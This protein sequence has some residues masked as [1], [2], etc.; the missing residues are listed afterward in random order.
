MKCDEFNEHIADLFDKNVDEIIVKTMNKHMATCEDCKREYDDMN[1]II[2]KVSNTQSAYTPSSDLKDRIFNQIK[3]EELIMKKTI[4]K[5]NILKKWHKQSIAA[6]ASILILVGVFIISNTNPFI[7]SAKA[8]ETIMTK[9]ITAMESLRSMFI[10]MDVRSIE[11]E[12]FDLISEDHDFIEYQIWKQFLGNKPWRV[13]KPGR[14]VTS[15]GEN[16]FL[17]M[18]EIKYAVTANMDV[19]FVEWIGIFLDPKD[20]IENE[21]DFAKTHNAKYEIN[22]TASTITLIIKSDALGNFNNN[23]RKNKSILESDNKRVYTFDRKTDLLKSFELFVN[24]DGK[25]TKILN[26]NNIAY[27]IPI[28]ASTFEIELP[29][30]TEWMKFND[31]EYKKDFSNTT[32]K[33]AAKLFFNALHKNDFTSIIDIWSILNITDNVII[34]EIK[35]RY[36]G[37][38]IIEIG[39]PYKS[40]L[41]PGDFV[42]YK[43]K[44]KSTEIVEGNLALRNDNKNKTWIVDGGI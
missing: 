8:A 26:I 39:E 43:L 37:L 28:Q 38:E 27:N 16:K 33:K 11:S 17:Y 18:P 44:I 24:S 34:E 21:I 10:S 23:H 1:L 4:T 6:A 3:T 2:H 5:K 15:N 22:K 14:V 20:I 35:L 36:G 7:T 30:G 40:G 32:S 41:F 42:P 29:S 12:P 13:E 25:S 9:S 31:P 19:H